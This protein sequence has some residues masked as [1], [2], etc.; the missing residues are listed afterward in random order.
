MY[1]VPKS[2]QTTFIYGPEIYEKLILNDHLLYKINEQV[3]FSFINKTCEEL[4]S[5]NKG[6]PVRNTPEMMLRSAVVQY[7]YDYSDRQMEYE[8]QVNI[9]V[10]WFIGLN[11]DDNAYDHSA[12]G[13]FRD[14][15]GND[16]WDEVFYQ[17]LKQI[18]DAGFS[19]GDTQYIDATH[20]IANIAIPGT[21]GIIRQ[22]ITEVLKSLKK[23]DHRLYKELGGKK[24]ALKKEKVHNLNQKEK[25]ERLVV[26]VKEARSVIQKT[27]SFDEPVK[28]KVE[29]LKRILGENVQ[30]EEGSICRRKGP[31]KDRIVNPVDPDARHG[32][33]SDEKKFVGYKVN[34]SMSEDRFI[35]NIKATCGNSYDGDVLLP[36]FNKGLANG[37]MINKIVADGGY[38]STEN[39]IEV[40]GK[41]ALLVAPVSKD[42]NTSGDYYPQATF[43]IDESGVI[44]PAGHRTMISY[45]DKKKGT[46]LYHFK[47][48]DCQ[49]CGLKQK[50]TKCDHRTI[51]VS[52]HYSIIEEAKNY[53]KS[54]QFK[55]DMR[56]RAHIEPKQGEMKRFHGLERAKFW[57][58][59]KLNVQAMLTAIVVN[60]KRFVKMNSDS[61]RS[62]C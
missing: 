2:K 37:Q 58:I 30:E 20:V 11:L 41:G 49:N 27:E 5:S 40:L 24:Q 44:C 28:E 61:C 16:K 47:K 9:M 60:L 53:G 39:R 34:S 25:E 32:A 15:L 38:G 6:R 18:Q 19:K 29:L 22:G 62:L 52:K 36:L 21:I 51:S 59:A 13:Y 1:S 17:I 14:K 48:S 7:L 12:L 42:A 45:Y 31:V 23:V 4:Y 56:M 3:D 35:T 55:E 26:I 50:C 57:G 8:A 46:T 54:E 10:K 43:T 33:K